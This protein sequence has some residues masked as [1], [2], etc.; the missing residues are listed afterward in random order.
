[1][2][3]RFK[4]TEAI[5]TI[6]RSGSADLILTGDRT[7]SIAQVEVAEVTHFLHESLMSR[8]WTVSDELRVAQKIIEHFGGEILDRDKIRE[9]IRRSWMKLLKRHLVPEPA[10]SYGHR[11]QE[12][13][14]TWYL[15]VGGQAGQ[16]VHTGGPHAHAAFNLG[17]SRLPGYPPDKSTSVEGE[18][19]TY[20]SPTW[21][22][23][24]QSVQDHGVSGDERTYEPC[25]HATPCSNLLARSTYLT[26]SERPTPARWPP[27]SSSLNP[28]SPRGI[29]SRW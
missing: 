19:G 21:S 20:H 7:D 29:P 26:L 25:H 22:R 10:Q 6:A 3:V 2:A 16:T 24:P 14:T 23:H 8:G 4:I 1:M 12:Y 17:G 15:F 5:L 27:G 9:T 13:L 11:K 28:T 18:V